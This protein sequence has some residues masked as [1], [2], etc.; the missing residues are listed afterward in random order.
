MVSPCLQ[1]MRYPLILTN[2]EKE[3]ARKVVLTF[4]Q[5][6]CGFDLLRSEVN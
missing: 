4:K 1:E 6:V 2:A 5:T 3:V